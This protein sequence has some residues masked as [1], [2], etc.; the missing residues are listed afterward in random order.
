MRSTGPRQAIQEAWCASVGPPVVVPASGGLPDRISSPA[1]SDRADGARL[2]HILS[3]NVHVGGG[4][5]EDV[6]AHLWGGR[7]GSSRP[8][9]VLLLEE[10][11]RS[12]AD[13]PGSYPKGLRVPSAIRPRRPGTDVVSLARRLDMALAYVPSM[14]NG[15]AT[16]LAEREDRG[17]AI[18]STEPLSQVT[19]IELPFGRQ[20]RV[21]VAAAVTPRS[22]A[23]RPFR[24]IVTH[25]DTSGDRVMQ[26]EAFVRSIGGL[27]GLPLVIGGDLNARRGVEDGTV[28]A[29]RQHVPLEPCGTGRTHRWPLRL[30]VLAFFV[31]RLDFIFSTLEA[32][33]LRRECRTLDDPF[34]SDHLPVL[35]TTEL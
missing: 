25:F 21:A 5:V 16:S 23:A 34:G 32:H 22:G 19:A 18:L 4:R 12:G 24:V 13:V 28:R 1:T 29:L 7:S 15:P 3:W 17:N 30:D 31:G 35:L 11:Y 27:R 2:L 8:A 10:V 6:L 26:A 14:R 33:G 20:R 9:T